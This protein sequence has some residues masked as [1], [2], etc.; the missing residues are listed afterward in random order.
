[1][2]KTLRTTRF[3][4]KLDKEGVN[5]KGEKYILLLSKIDQHVKKWYMK[6]IKKPSDYYR[7]KMIYVYQLDLEKE[8]CRKFLEEKVKMNRFKRFCFFWFVLIMVVIFIYN[9]FSFWI[10]HFLDGGLV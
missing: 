4:E 8:E 10:P 5:M 2:R 6:L 7:D 3:D 1:M 9:I